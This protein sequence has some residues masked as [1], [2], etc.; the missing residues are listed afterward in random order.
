MSDFDE[1]DVIKGG[2]DFDAADVISETPKAKKDISTIESANAGIQQGATLGGAPIIQGAIEGGMDAV[3]SALAKLSIM[4][5]SPSD[6]NSLMAKEGFKGDLGPQT[7]MDMYRGAR[8]ASTAEFDAAAEAHPVANFAGGLAGSIATLPLLPAK[9]L[10]PIGTA[11]KG[12][13]MLTKAG[14]AAANAVPTAAVASANMSKGDLTKGEFGQVAQDT[15]IGTALGAGIGGGLQ[16]GGSTLGKVGDVLDSVTPQVMK[17]AYARGKEGIN[18][19]KDKFYKDTSANLTQMA[20]DIEAPITAKSKAQV[21]EGEAYL[22]KLQADEAALTKDFDSMTAEAKA[23]ADLEIERQTAANAMDV[24]RINEKSVETAKNLQKHVIDTRKKLGNKYNE[25]DTAA[26]ATEIYPDSRESLNGFMEEIADNAGLPESD[27]KGIAKK[28]ES[29]MNGENP[30]QAF[31]NTKQ[32]LNK[33]FDHGNPVVRRAAKAAYARTKTD[34]AQ[35]LEAGG[36]KELAADIADT[37]KKWMATAEIEN[38]FVDNLKPNRSTGKVEVAPATIDAVQTFNRNNPKAIAKSDFLGGILNV[39][40]PE[41]SP[42]QIKAM[43]DLAAEA[44]QVKNFKPQAPELP[45]MPPEQVTELQRLQDLQAQFKAAQ[46]KKNPADVVPGAVLPKK[47]Q[48]LQN[49]LIK[50]LPKYEAQSGDTVSENTLESIL[51]FLKGEKGGDFV[52]TLKPKMKRLSEDVG[53]RD[54]VTG[55]QVEDVPVSMLD[56]ARKFIGKSSAGIGNKAGLGAKA[57]ADNKIVQGTGK[58]ASVTKEFMTKPRSFL[59]TGTKDLSKASNEDLTMVAEGIA[60][61]GGEGPGFARVLNEAQSK[62]GQGRSAVMFGLMQRKE[63]RELVD[64]LN[65]ES[66]NV[67]EPVK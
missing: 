8:D 50:T 4:D 36:Y 29:S 67:S 57:I 17:D 60:K 58:V 30:S 35:A 61:M 34:Y 38:E 48:E 47:S 64:K 49:T 20:G 59:K 14:Y 22:A 10:A 54:A 32:V 9:M 65:M 45:Q 21:A 31:R 25:L 19:L 27:L 18:V 55:G 41:G 52:D 39:M 63:F 51:G 53:I 16:L 56:A 1:K 6:T 24:K 3:Q 23:H 33:L 43:Q 13:G 44:N 66:D 42:A 37:N 62:Q 12:A 5:P 11:A 40:D 2:G 26:E 15:A 28:L 7:S 46:M